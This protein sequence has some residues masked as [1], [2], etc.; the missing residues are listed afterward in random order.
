MDGTLPGLSDGLSAAIDLSTTTPPALASVWDT[1]KCIE[2]EKLDNLGCGNGYEPAGIEALREAVAA[3]FT[4][5]GLPTHAEEVLVT[6]GALQGIGLV[7]SL[8]LRPGDRV[9][10]EDP[11][12]PMVLSSLRTT[13]ARLL[14]TPVD[15]QGVDPEHVEEAFARTSPNL[16]YVTP[17]FHNPTG[18]VM[19][20]LRRQRLGMMARRFQIP[21]I[22]DLSVEDI[23]LQGDRHSPI[24]AFAPDAPILSVG[25][26]SKLF[27]A[28][29]RIGWVRGPAAIIARLTRLKAVQDLGSPLLAQVHATKLLT[30]TDEARIERRNQLAPRLDC[31]AEMLSERLPD[32]HWQRPRGGLSV[33]VRMPAGD[34]RAFAQVVQRRGIV[35]AP[36]TVFSVGE[37][38]E[39]YLRIPFVL[40]PDTLVTGI[41]HLARAWHAW[42]PEA[43]T[44][45]RTSSVVV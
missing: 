9:V 37:R 28:G 18:A 36:G 35:I 26:L 42:K 5:R 10:V 4:D 30:R 27:W 1:V 33:W 19:D 3:F 38:H 29:L 20:E 15:T 16:A 13:R 45:R 7:A 44:V 21:I 32:W 11:T 39:E 12:C 40:E 8:F 41:E 25:S 22:E 2:V 6:N 43:L 17:I 24:A 31:L 23:A 34:T 14:P